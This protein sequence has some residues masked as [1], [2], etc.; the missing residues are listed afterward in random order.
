M[1]PLSA[2]MHNINMQLAQLMKQAAKVYLLQS[3]IAEMSH[4]GFKEMFLPRIKILEI[5][6]VN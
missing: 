4:Q 3:K 2:R 1:K 5:Q 6:F